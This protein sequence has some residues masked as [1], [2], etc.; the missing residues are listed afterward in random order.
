MEKL[1]IKQSYA[2]LTAKK[3]K[4]KKSKLSRVLRYRKPCV[5]AKGLPITCCAQKNL[6]GQAQ[7]TNLKLSKNLG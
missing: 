4:E 7:Y 2:E 3:K 1:T 6:V 5:R